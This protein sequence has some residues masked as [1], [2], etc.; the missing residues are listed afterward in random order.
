MGGTALGNAATVTRQVVNPDAKHPP[1]RPHPRDSPTVE[2]LRHRTEPH[3]IQAT[4]AGESRGSKTWPL[5]LEAG[6]T[7]GVRYAG[8]EIRFA[9]SFED[10]RLPLACR[11]I[12]REPGSGP[13][14]PPPASG[15]HL[16][17][18]GPPGCSIFQ[19]RDSSEAAQARLRSGV[20][21]KWCKCKRRP[22]RS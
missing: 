16:P 8:D 21:T 22:S 15:I 6:G 19:A 11:P 7:F 5:L 9:A 13:V 2:N 12:P 10:H 18:F 4:G 14:Q 3:Q 20:G 17:F 1:E